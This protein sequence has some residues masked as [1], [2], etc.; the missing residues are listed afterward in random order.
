MQPE[1]SGPE[2]THPLFEITPLTAD[3]AEAYA[4]LVAD[5][6]QVV[7]CTAQKSPTWVGWQKKTPAYEDVWHHDG[8]IA[9]IPASRRLV[10]F[11]AD[12]GTADDI[13][14]FAREF[15][16]L[17]QLPSRQPGR[18]HFFYPTTKLIKNSW[19]QWR[20]VS[21]DVR[22]HA[23]Y[24]VLWGDNAR[25]LLE[26]LMDPNQTST[27]APLHLIQKTPPQTRAKLAPQRTSTSDP[28]PP[29]G[30]SGSPGPIRFDRLRQ[31][32]YRT[33]RG[34]DRAAWGL[35]VA[36]E[37]RR[38]N[39]DLPDPLPMVEVAS[40]AAS[41]AERVWNTLPGHYLAKG[42][43][44]TTELARQMG[45][46]SGVKRRKGTALEHDRTPWAAEG[47]SRRTWFR[48]RASTSDTPTIPKA[49][50]P[51]LALGISE[52]A[53]RQRLSRARA[54][55]YRGA[56]KGV[57]PWDYLA[58]GEA[59][60]WEYY[61]P[62]APCHPAPAP[63][64]NCHKNGTEQIGGRRAEGEGVG[65][66]GDTTVDPG[67][68]VER[69]PKKPHQVKMSS[70]QVSRPLT[71]KVPTAGKSVDKK[72][73]IDPQRRDAMRRMRDMEREIIVDEYLQL[74]DLAYALELRCRGV[75][76]HGLRQPMMP[77]PEYDG[78]NAKHRQRYAIARSQKAKHDLGIAGE[79]YAREH[80]LGLVPRVSPWRDVVEHWDPSDSFVDQ[81]LQDRREWMQET[82]HYWRKELAEEYAIDQAVL[83]VRDEPTRNCLAPECRELAQESDVLCNGCRGLASALT[84][85]PNC[86]EW[87]SKLL[88]TAQP[89]CPTCT[90]STP[91][92]RATRTN[93]LVASWNLLRTETRRAPV[94]RH[95]PC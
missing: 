11:D 87:E 71:K 82:R 37:A 59:E 45:L 67:R 56:K 6:C 73:D 44:W 80:A 2:R 62:G 55:T 7:L 66:G 69:A 92:Q 51:H 4:D 23:G 72:A 91:E 14:A 89:E 34:T 64:K 21:G 16:P 43:E 90:M 26:A 20:G 1:T 49:P 10:V 32:A 86:G 61:A 28:E 53:W 79:L 8:P 22:S 57:P 50:A 29:R 13:A 58:I 36:A 47:I 75:E 94:R 39:E 65:G 54:G 78:S 12:A 40:M 17:V 15:R 88:L 70:D 60:W 76:P 95:L 63:A 25:G 48:R 5:G 85:C 31:W 41:V 19:F 9:L 3:Q 84:Q 30:R 52:D 74:R 18:W 81:Y 24:V 83:L 33:P 93:A 38:L 42:G 35:R 46:A 68:G 77:Y 27:Q